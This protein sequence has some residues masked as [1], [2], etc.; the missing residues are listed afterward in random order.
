MSRVV[1]WLGV[2]FSVSVGLPLLEN[3]PDHLQELRRTS[4]PRLV[5]V[6]EVEPRTSDLSIVRRDLA[7]I[8]SDGHAES[9]ASQEARLMTVNVWRSWFGVR[10]LTEKE[11]VHAMS[12]GATNM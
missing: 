7:S 3:D 11:L 2:A 6:A 5:D 1:A 12:M 4:L 8:K 9:N 10:P